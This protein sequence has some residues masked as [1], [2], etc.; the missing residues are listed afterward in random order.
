L[1]EVLTDASCLEMAQDNKSLHRNAAGWSAEMQRLSAS[2]ELGRYAA[3]SF[4]G[5]DAIERLFVFTDE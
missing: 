2:G 4:F 5:G 3:Q 1:E